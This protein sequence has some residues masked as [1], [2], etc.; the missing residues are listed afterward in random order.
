MIIL[1]LMHPTASLASLCGPNLGWEQK[2]TGCSA[3]LKTPQ[4]HRV[5]GGKVYFLL[6]GLSSPLV[7]CVCSGAAVCSCRGRVAPLPVW[8]L[9]RDLPLVKQRAHDG[10]GQGARPRGEGCWD[11]L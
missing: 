2:R 9:S 3:L 11:E 6:R 10:P 4:L 1:P 5:V 7:L 8:F